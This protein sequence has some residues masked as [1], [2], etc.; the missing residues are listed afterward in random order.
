[1]TDE[2]DYKSQILKYRVDDVRRLALHGMLKPELLNVL[3][4]HPYVITVAYSD[5]DLEKVEKA[6]SLVAEEEEN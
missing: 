2:E 6:K 5:L 4:Y 3:E 1:M